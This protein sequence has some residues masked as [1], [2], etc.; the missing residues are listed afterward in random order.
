MNTEFFILMIIFLFR[1]RGRWVHGR[2][3]RLRG[4][5]WQAEDMAVPFAICEKPLLR[6][7][8]DDLRRLMCNFERSP[9]CLLRSSRGYASRDH[10]RSEIEHSARTQHAF[11][12]SSRPY[13]P[14]RDWDLDESC[15]LRCR[16]VSIIF[17]RR[18]SYQVLKCAPG[19]NHMKNE[20][21]I[22]FIK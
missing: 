17:K 8:K 3:V 16:S 7:P 14:L 21:I 4:A 10:H 22:Q 15:D 11:S 13:S 12:S 9:S 5:D 19:R 2:G 1:T 18:T 6:V 20:C